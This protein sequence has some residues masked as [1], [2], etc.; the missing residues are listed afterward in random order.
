MSPVCVV[1]M[2][3]RLPSLPRVPHLLPVCDPVSE[4]G[5]GDGWS[6]RKGSQRSFA[7]EPEETGRV[8]RVGDGGAP[9]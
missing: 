8:E 7:G 6:S 1:S 9:V 3:S 4:T 5:C 2:S